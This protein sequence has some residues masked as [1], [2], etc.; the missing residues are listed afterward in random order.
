MKTA[1]AVFAKTPGV[2]P[3]KTRLAAGIGKEKAE[4]FYLF[5]LKVAREL[6]QLVRE[7]SKHEVTPYWALAEQEGADLPLWSAFDTLWTGEGGLGKR[8]HTVSAGLLMEYDQ[9]LLIGTDIPQLRP[10]ILLE[11]IE[12][13]EASPESCVIG[14]SLDGGFYLI[15]SSRPIPE[16]V[17]TNVTYSRAD[18]LE[19]LLGRMKAFRIPYTFLKE[20]G[21]IDESQDL[22]ALHQVLSQ[23]QNRILP[24][25]QRLYEWM[26]TTLDLLCKKPKAP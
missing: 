9:V 12:R 11:A 25:Q 16:E 26:N 21:D 8:M 15:G 23:K 14:P 6:I 19:Q 24:G 7:Q 5:S 17:W 22:K 20:L 4:E 2:S 13:L 1:I 10:E 3:I 18:T